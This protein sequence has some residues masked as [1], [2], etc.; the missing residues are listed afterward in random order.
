M[1]I[2]FM[3]NN[4]FLEKVKLTQFNNFPALTGA[5]EKGEQEHFKRKT[6]PGNRFEINPTMLMV[7]KTL[8]FLED[9]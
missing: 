2:C 1:V 9:F 4:I 7:Q 6:L 5:Q 8:H 3:F